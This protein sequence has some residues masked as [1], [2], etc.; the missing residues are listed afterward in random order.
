MAARTITLDGAGVA[1]ADIAS[2]ARHGVRVRLCPD[3]LGRAAAARAAAEEV[4]GRRAVYG[5]TTG[6]GANRTQ[7]AAGDDH[8]VRLLRSHAGGIGAVLPPEQV[9]AMLAVR[10][11]QI[12]AGGGGTDPAFAVAMAE[13]LGS[14]YLPRVHEFGSLGTGDLTALAETALTLTGE[15]PWVATPDAHGGPPAAVRP[16]PGDALAFCSS[17]ALTVGQAVLGWDQIVRSLRAAQVVAALS[18]VAV[19]AGTEPYHEYVHVRRPHPGPAAVAAETRRLLGDDR[20]VPVRQDPGGPAPEARRLLGDDRPVPARVQDPFAHRCHPQ[21]HGAAVE[22]ADALERTLAVE[23][24]AAAENPLVDASAGTV[25]HHGGFHLASLTLALD[26]LRLAVLNTAHLSAAR[27]SSLMDPAFTGLR[28][29]LAD[30]PDGSSGLMVL[31]YSASSALAEL[32]A[33]AYPASLG[34]TA[35]SRGL[36]EHASFASQAARQTLDAGRAYRLVLACELVTAV[37]A[38]RG[39]ALSPATPAGEAFAVAAAVLDPRTGD[40]PL[41]EDVETAAGLL[42]RLAEI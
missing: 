12:L 40:R 8:G 29:F 25:H 5:R 13:A 38:L 28:P 31:E 6:V 17:G 15:R 9:R 27:L 23:I 24:N 21:V 22:A 16:R 32:R 2:V 14:G 26:H 4:A 11:N 10:V 34:H 41:T 1:A 19:H 37:R 33:R 39:R 36:E 30:G 3:G 42:G 7:A 35:V 18:L 20:P